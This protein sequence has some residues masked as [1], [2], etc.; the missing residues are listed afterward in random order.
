MLKQIV[1][2]GD[3]VRFARSDEH[4]K[5]DKRSFVVEE[6]L[7]ENGVGTA[8]TA[9]SARIVPIDGDPRW[10]IKPVDALKHDDSGDAIEVTVA[11]GF[12]GNPD[13]WCWW[14]Y[15]YPED[16]VFGGYHT[17]DLVMEDIARQEQRDPTFHYHVSELVEVVVDEHYRQKH[18]QLRNP[19]PAGDVRRRGQSQW[20]PEDISAI[21]RLRAQNATLLAE[22][23]EHYPISITAQAFYADEATLKD[24]QTL[25]DR[26]LALTPEQQLTALP[27][28]LRAAVPK[29]E[30]TTVTKENDHE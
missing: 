26:H 9:L 19:V 17:K 3:K 1:R 24:L 5:A 25:I 22:L 15:E 6:V 23:A 28:R 18:P 21:R 2:K 12:L 20:T 7:P 4:P 14:E 27:P 10:L 8:R 30:E 16:G 11:P 13:A 29:R